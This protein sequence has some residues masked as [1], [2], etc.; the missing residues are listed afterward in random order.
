MNR[1]PRF[2]LLLAV[3]TGGF[4]GLQEI[5]EPRKTITFSRDYKLLH[6]PWRKLSPGG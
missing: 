1:I 3:R 2:N 5:G 4:W 6:Q